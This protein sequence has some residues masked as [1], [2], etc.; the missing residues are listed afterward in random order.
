[1]KRVT[2]A[3]AVTFHCWDDCE[4]R[5]NW[6]YIN[7]LRFQKRIKQIDKLIGHVFDPTHRLIVYQRYRF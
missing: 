7:D 4:D 2:F 5:R 6:I 3:I 1:M